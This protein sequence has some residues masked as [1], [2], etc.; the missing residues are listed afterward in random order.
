MKTGKGTLLRIV[1]PLHMNDISPLNGDG[2]IIG[3]EIVV[4]FAVVHQQ[5]TGVIGDGVTFKVGGI[6]KLKLVGGN[7]EGGLPQF[8]LLL[9]IVEPVGVKGGAVVGSQFNAAVFQT[10]VDDDRVAAVALQ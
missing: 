1:N 4:K 2:G 6:H 5:V 9:Q 7:G 3:S 8:V 10:A